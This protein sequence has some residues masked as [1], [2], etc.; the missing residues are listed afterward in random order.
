MDQRW[1]ESNSVTKED[2]LVDL[3]AIGLGDKHLVG[4]GCSRMLRW[5]VVVDRKFRVHEWIF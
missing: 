3:L 1:I 4:F 2:S 5:L